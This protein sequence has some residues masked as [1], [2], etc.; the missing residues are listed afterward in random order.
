MRIENLI[1]EEIE[2]RHKVSADVGG[3]R[4]WFESA[5][6]ELQPSP[7]VFGSA[8]LIP[9]LF[10][11]KRL[12]FDDPVDGVWLSNAVKILPTVKQWWG[13]PLLGP[14]AG[15]IKDSEEVSEIER[16]TRTGSGLCFTGG[17]DSFFT[18]LRSGRRISHLI[19]VHG[20]DIPL[21]DIAR[22]SAFRESFEL[23]AGR[24]GI[25][26]VIIRTNL[27]DHPAFR[28]SSWQL[29]HGGALAAIGHLLNHEV[30]QFLISSS[31]WH[32]MDMPWGSHWKIDHHWSSSKL[33]IVNFGAQYP[34]YR[35]LIAI[36]GDPLVRHHLRVC[37]ENR[38]PAGNC[39]KCEKCVATRLILFECGELDN[40]PVFA[41]GEF[42]TEEIGALP[43]ISG[44]FSH[45]Q[46][47]M[48]SER[49]SPSL[50]E[51]ISSQVVREERRVRRESSIYYQI[52]KKLKSILR[53][54]L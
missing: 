41:S 18:L 6:V 11:K 51:V 15:A 7:E 50:R 14:H 28:E 9:A 45:F 8:F 54:R 35:K 23:I 42:L 12:E 26:P 48:N 31:I 53:S 20:F 44:S 16:D 40:F 4:V 1:R 47:V 30:G 29:T 25:K 10:Q 32:E 37:W 21:D 49:L 2:G 34:R 36:A 39:S 13:L 3:Y 33:E 27:R 52:Y 17:V 43:R 46:F 24:F 5:E 19:Y 22:F 38:S